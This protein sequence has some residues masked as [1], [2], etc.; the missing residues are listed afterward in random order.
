MGTYRNPSEGAPTYGVMRP[1]NEGAHVDGSCIAV[2]DIDICEAGICKH[3][4]GN[5]LKVRKVLPEKKD[6]TAINYVGS[7]GGFRTGETRVMSAEYNFEFPSHKGI[8][9]NFSNE[10]LFKNKKQ[11]GCQEIMVKITHIMEDPMIGHIVIL[12]VLN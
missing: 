12:E 6:Y 4:E 8:S 5:G 9:F 3:V 11:H 7:V 2:G 10:W 1:I